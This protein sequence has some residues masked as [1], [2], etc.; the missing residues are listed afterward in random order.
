MCLSYFFLEELVSVK[1][2]KIKFRLK[3]FDLVWFS[4]FFA[5]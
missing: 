3:F 4:I 2:V 1:Q 5:S